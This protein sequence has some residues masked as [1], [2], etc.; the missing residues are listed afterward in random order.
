MATRRRRAAPSRLD[1]PLRFNE[2]LVL[3]QWI[4]SLF[5]VESF[6]KLSEDLKNPDLEA[7]DEDNISFFY[8]QLTQRLFEHGQLSNEVLLGYDEN[9]YRHT[10]RLNEPERTDSVEVF[11]VSFAALH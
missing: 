6:A 3:N 9:I 2:K 4:L 8:H 11:P 1:Q 5:E 7:Y 10:H